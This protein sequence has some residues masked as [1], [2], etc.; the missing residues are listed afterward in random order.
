MLED[1][2]F[3][4]VSIPCALDDDVLPHSEMGVSATCSARA[5]FKARAV[6]QALRSDWAAGSSP[7]QGILLAADTLC[8]LDGAIMGKA[9][10]PDEARAMIRALV[11]RS[12]R[13]ITGVALLDRATDQRAIWCDSTQVT[14]GDLSEE[15]IDAYIDSDQWRGKS[16]CYNFTDR[17]DAG[18]PL[19]CEG[20]PST[21]MGLPMTRLAP[22]LKELLLEAPQ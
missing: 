14:L 15:S 11:G 21:V 2:G 17:V 18:W 8:E 19:T 6:D 4:P 1:A 13:T 16:G 10:T 5:W 22:E 9:S 12:H 20:D 3:Q 7:D